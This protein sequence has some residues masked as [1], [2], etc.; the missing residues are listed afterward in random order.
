MPYLETALR[1]APVRR[2]RPARASVGK[3]DEDGAEFALAAERPSTRDADRDR[4]PRSGSTSRASTP[5][6]RAIEARRTSTKRAAAP[7]RAARRYFC[8]GLPATT[9]RRPTRTTRLLGVGNRVATTM[10]LLAPRGPRHGHGPHAD[11]RRGRA[12][13]SAWGP[14]TGCRALRAE[15]SATGNVPPLRLA[16][17]IRF[18]ARVG[19][20]TSPTSCSTTRPSP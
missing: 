10:V 18:A 1:D 13:S 15:T 17:P 3:C 11:G 5:A 2:A 7:A 14:F 9:P 4:R 20:E 16:G 6:S 12:S 8:S 19:R